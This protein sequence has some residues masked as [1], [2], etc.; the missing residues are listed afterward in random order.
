MIKTFKHK[1]LQKF[2]EDGSK[3]GILTKH[4]AR[5]FDILDLLN[6]ADSI[7]V[8]G[9]PGSRLHLLNPKQAKTGS[10]TVSGNW[11]IIFKFENG[12][13]YDVDYIDHH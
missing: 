8:M 3:K 4:T 13:A 12:D 10:V 1:G 11:R 2:Y 6:A 5:I 7:Q 9:F